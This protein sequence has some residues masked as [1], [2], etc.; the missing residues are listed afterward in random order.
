VVTY[1]NEFDKFAAQWLRSLY[2]EAV[3]DERS[4]HEVLPADISRFR[5]CHFFGG[6]GGW[7]FALDL[8]GW[9]ADWPIWTGSCP[10]QP[11]SAAGKGEGDADERNLWP[12]FFRLI[13]ECRPEFIFGEQV[14]AAVRHGWLDGV[15]ADLEREGYAVGA[16]VLGAHSVGAP[17]IRQRLYWVANL[18]RDGRRQGSEDERRRNCGVRAEGHGRGPANGCDDGRVVESASIGPWEASKRGCLGES[19]AA[20]RERG[21]GGSGSSGFVG[22]AAD[23]RLPRRQDAGADRG[24]AGAVELRC[25]EPERAVPPGWDGRL[26]VANG[27]RCATG[28]GAGAGSDTQPGWSCFATIPCRDGKARRISAQPGDEPLVNGIPR[29]LG[30]GEPE[31][32]RLAR[33]A[34]AN[35]TGRL[36][37][38]G[39][40]VVPQ[41]A[42]AFIRAFMEEL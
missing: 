11:Y 26:V 24:N 22:D 6:I 27:E 31:L 13:R 9:P 33:R 7:E 23:A 20:G 40:A 19:E 12:E 16:A 17:H 14:E 5:R 34:R 2:P 1:F 10:C 41:V 35:R 3:V 18:A 21:V 4:I 28:A 8:A 15:S 38:Y 36:R 32:G 29:E 42:A 30:R 39:N 25:R 37:G